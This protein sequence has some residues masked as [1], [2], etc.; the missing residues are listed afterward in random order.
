MADVNIYNSTASDN[1]EQPH[2]HILLT[3]R[4]IDK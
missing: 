4:K 3:L 2:A 1:K